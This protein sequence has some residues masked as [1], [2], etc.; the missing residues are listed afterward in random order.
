MRWLLPA[1]VLALVIF[2][3]GLYLTFAGPEGVLHRDS[4]SHAV[5]GGRSGTLATS[6]PLPAAATATPTSAP[7]N[8]KL[9]MSEPRLVMIG[10]DE[11]KGPALTLNLRFAPALTATLRVDAIEDRKSTRLNSS[12]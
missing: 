5:V 6:V 4:L 12:H 7:A 11:T 3:V 2:A 1:Y 8:G 9:P 10:V